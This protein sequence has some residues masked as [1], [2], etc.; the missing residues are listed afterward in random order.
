MKVVLVCWLVADR[1][2]VMEKKLVNWIGGA[3][4]IIKIVHPRATSTSYINMD[5][6]G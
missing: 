6:E 3:H 2:S 5:S 1:N 4:Y